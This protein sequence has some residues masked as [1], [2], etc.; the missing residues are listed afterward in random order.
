[1]RRQSH[2][3][4]LHLTRGCVA[5]FGAFARRLTCQRESRQVQ[6]L[7]N[8]PAYR[9]KRKPLSSK[10]QLLKNVANSIMINSSRIALGVLIILVFA[11]RFFRTRQLYLTSLNSLKPIAFNPQDFHGFV[12]QVLL[13]RRS[14]EPTSFFIRGFVFAILA[15]GLLPFKNYEPILCILVIVLVTIYVPWCIMHGVMLRKKISQ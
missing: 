4:R 12:Q 7:A 10:F 13:G 1:M 6:P 3:P 9:D 2:Q 5:I 14:I 15:I 11:W 8:I